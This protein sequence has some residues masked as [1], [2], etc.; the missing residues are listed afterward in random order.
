[1]F[2]TTKSVFRNAYY[3]S[4]LLV[5]DG[6]LLIILLVGYSEN[7]NWNIIDLFM[8]CEFSILFWLC[9]IM[10]AISA[11]AAYYVKRVLK[12]TIGASKTLNA[13]KRHIGTKYNTGFRE[14]LWSIIIPM[15]STYSIVDSPILSFTMILVLQTLV[16]FFYI[17]SSDMFPNLALTFLGYSVYICVTEDKNDFFVFGKRKEIDNIIGKDKEVVPLSSITD[18][19]NNVGVIKE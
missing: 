2:R 1:M 12:E 16:Y 4:S 6:L 11:L 5:P 17:N 10:L 19:Y 13:K 7:N 9:V 18:K 14:F 15:I 8:I 3:L